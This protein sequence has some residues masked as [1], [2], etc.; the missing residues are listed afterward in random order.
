MALIYFD[1]AFCYSTGFQKMTTSEKNVIKVVDSD[2]QV[3][4]ATDVQLDLAPLIGYVSQKPYMAGSSTV[5]GIDGCFLFSLAKGND[6]IGFKFTQILGVERTYSLKTF[7][8]GNK[9][10]IQ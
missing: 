2:T 3:L 7:P 1:S 8:Q 9:D 6:A 5:G 10:R 4:L